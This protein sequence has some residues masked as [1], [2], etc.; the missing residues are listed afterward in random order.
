MRRPVYHPAV[1]IRE[2][3][4]MI[5][6]RPLLWSV[7]ATLVAA[8]GARAQVSS[9]PVPGVTNL[10]RIESTVACAGATTPE[11]MRAVKEMGFASVVNLREASEPNANVEAES[12][13]AKAAGLRYVHLPLNRESPDPAVA[14]RFV[15]AARD[16]ANQPM[17]IHCASGNRAAAM[18]LIKR[19]VVDG[20][21]LERATAEAETLGLEHEPWK[22]F[23]RDYVKAHKGS[24]PN[25]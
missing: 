2:D 22:Q 11:S 15:T 1:L 23:A 25:P 18:W 12:A 13:A 9:E 8:S 4:S 17:F 14:D 3:C 10:H 20:W 6:L 7:L 5:R 24:I 21:P 19:T 16:P